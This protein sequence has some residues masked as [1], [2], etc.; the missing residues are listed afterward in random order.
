MSG[1][2]LI[3]GT[4]WGE[5]GGGGGSSFVELEERERKIWRFV[6]QGASRPLDP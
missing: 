2:N 1:I 3:L 6:R 4:G 5:A